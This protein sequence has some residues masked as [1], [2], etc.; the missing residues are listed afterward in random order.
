MPFRRSLGWA[1]LTLSFLL[2]GCDQT[3]LTAPAIQAASGGSGSA[4]AAPSL[5]SA[6]ALSNTQI[7]VAWRDN[8]SS[9]LG[10]EVQ[11]SSSPN[12]AYSVRL[13]TGPNVTS[14]R[15]DG[16]SASSQFCYKIR[17]LRRTGN[18]TSYSA[19]SN[20]ACAST[21]SVPPPSAPSGLGVASASSTQMWVWWTDNSANEDGFRVERSIDAGGSWVAS[22]TSGANQSHLVDQGLTPEQELCYRVIAFNAGGDSPPSNTQCTTPPAGPTDLTVSGFDS[23]TMLV[24]VTWTDNSA[25]EDGYDVVRCFEDCT[26]YAELPPNTT[27]YETD[28]SDSGS[29]HVIARKDS[30]YSDGSNWLNPSWHPLCGGT[31]WGPGGESTTKR[32]AP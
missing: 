11:R 17:A 1:G 29:M 4:V 25:V 3:P 30:G 10:F 16:L 24:I 19:F 23:T 20:T 5:A 15:D 28:C 27:S 9:E 18:N 22:A 14:F 13:S 2:A 7:D 21:L 8:S 32:G 12:G 31:G 26:T 6:T